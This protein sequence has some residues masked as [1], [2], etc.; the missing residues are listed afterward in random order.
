MTLA[1][2]DQAAAET[3]RER[4]SEEATHLASIARKFCGLTAPEPAL[5]GTDVI[6]DVETL[7][8]HI[9]DLRSKLA[10]AA[11]A[12]ATRLAESKQ[13][14]PVGLA[15]LTERCLQAKKQPR[16]VDAAGL[17]GIS[18]RCAQAINQTEPQK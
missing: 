7:A 4:L 15:T 18:A 10:T 9:K 11:D 3:L 2:L 16:K 13:E 8:A 5:T 1:N 6:Q 17:S 12:S 14:D